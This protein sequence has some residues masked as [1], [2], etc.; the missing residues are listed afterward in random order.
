M[1]VVFFSGFVSYFSFSP[2]EGR[3]SAPTKNKI[4]KNTGGKEPPKK[5]TS[6]PRW[7]G[8]NM[9][10]KIDNLC[11]YLGISRTRLAKSIGYSETHVRDIANV[12]DKPKILE[13]IAEKY[14]FDV[15]YFYSDRDISEF[16][17]KPKSK[18]EQQAEIGARMKERRLELG[19]IQKDIVELTGIS[20]SNVSN[21]EKGTVSA[22]VATFKEIAAA[23]EVGVEWLME[24]DER[25]KENPVDD[26]MVEWLKDHPEERKSIRE[27][28]KCD[29]WTHRKNRRFK[30]NTEK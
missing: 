15:E 30:K 3:C 24:G 1:G 7:G 22:S 12:L 2:R 17:A 5:K 10:E 27:K 19:Y 29:G 25:N 13:V 11:A 9:K 18:E 26:D 8:K 28:M 4:K 21:I 20:K 6:H 23:L 14:G 16:L